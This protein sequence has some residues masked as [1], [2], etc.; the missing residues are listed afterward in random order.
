MAIS[1][2]QPEKFPHRALV[3]YIVYLMLMILRVLRSSIDLTTDGATQEF[4]FCT[5]KQKLSNDVSA[6]TVQRL[7]V[8]V[9]EPSMTPQLLREHCFGPSY[10]LTSAIDVCVQTPPFLFIS[11]QAGCTSEMSCPKIPSS[12][13]VRWSISAP[14]YNDFLRNVVQGNDQRIDPPSGKSR[15]TQICSG[16]RFIRQPLFLD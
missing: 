11:A 1:E 9:A 5:N 3:H 2:D 16:S 10:A 14:S 8:S 12:R 6:A 4:C 13:A 7:A 15:S